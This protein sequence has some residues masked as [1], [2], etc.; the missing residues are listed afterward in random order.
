MSK[1]I[2]G[3]CACG[4]IRYECASEPVMGGHCQCRDCQRHTGAGHVSAFV[5]PRT[6]VKV[7]SRPK[8]YES[9]SDGGNAVRRGFCPE[10]GSSVL[11]DNSGMPDMVY[12]MAASL[13]DP[14]IFK[15]GVVAYTASA[16]PWDYIDPKLPAFPGM[17][18][19]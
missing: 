13:D 12:I 19:M 9:R 18:K 2:S 11:A 1:P 3:G 6:A 15:P 4:A 14:S 5:V 17:P 10:C 7:T 16:Q 8:Y